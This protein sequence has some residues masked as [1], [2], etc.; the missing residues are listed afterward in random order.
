MENTMHRIRVAFDGWLERN[1]DGH[2]YVLSPDKTL[3]NRLD[4]FVTGYQLA[5][6]REAGLPESLCKSRVE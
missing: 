3:C 2:V 5:A 4:C 6:L 1:A